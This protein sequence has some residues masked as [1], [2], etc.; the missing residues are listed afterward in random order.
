MAEDILGS[1]LVPLITA[2][3]SLVVLLAAL[4]FARSRIK[5]GKEARGEE[6]IPD[7]AYN[8]LI[9]TEAISRG[10]EAKGFENVRAA[11]LL[12]EARQAYYEGRHREVERIALEAR[13][14]LEQMRQDEE[15]SEPAVVE[16]ELELPE[17]RPIQGKEFPKNYLQAKFLMSVVKDSLK[18]KKASSPETKEVRK[19][20]KEAKAAFDEKRYGEAVSIAVSC[21]KLLKGEEAPLEQE[22]GGCP[23]CGFPVS[24]ED[25][26]CG[27][28]GARLQG[29]L[30]CPECGV[31]IGED[32]SFCRKCGAVVKAVPPAAG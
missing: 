25:T 9:T 15:P 6:F 19:L 24:P 27:K 30:M 20:M 13:G 3:V 22:K 23:G 1:T 21:K 17:S 14:L 28:C 31:Q 12:E 32:D 16:E 2:I 4:G 26:F 8:T 18:K 11:E 5:R 10:M 29:Q 7:R